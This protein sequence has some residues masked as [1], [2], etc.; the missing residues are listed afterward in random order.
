MSA[1]P[2]VPEGTL[3][4][5]R[6]KAQEAKTLELVVKDKERELSE[7]KSQLYAILSDELPSMCV[8]AGIA[9]LEVAADGNLPA[10]RLKIAAHYKANIPVDWPEERRTAAFEYLEDR[11]AEAIIKTA[12]IVEFPKE[13]RAKAN[14]LVEHLRNWG[15]DFE[16]KAS[17][18]W[19]TLTSWLRAEIEGPVRRGEAPFPDLNI[20]GGSFGKV[21]KLREVGD[22]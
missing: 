18:N 2:D 8:E 15:L 22:D 12:V 4:A 17:V 5:I 19:S 20:I 16:V 6:A 13:D 9:A 3:A 21:A 7:A 14:R 1:R 11:G 10:F